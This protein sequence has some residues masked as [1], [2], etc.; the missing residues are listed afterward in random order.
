M[1][2]EARISY[3]EMVI[4]ARAVDIYVLKGGQG[5][6]GEYVNVGRLEGRPAQDH[7]YKYHYR[8]GAAELP[9]TRVALLQLR[10][11][12]HSEGAA[13]IYVFRLSV[14]VGESNQRHKANIATS[15]GVGVGAASRWG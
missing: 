7:P 10:L 5:A 14:V 9:D 11:T 6:S 13:E 15:L 2:T 8:F 1:E 3:L 12:P 4:S